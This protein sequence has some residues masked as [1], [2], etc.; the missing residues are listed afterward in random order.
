MAPGLDRALSAAANPS[1]AGLPLGS[2][3]P[4]LPTD[5]KALSVATNPTLR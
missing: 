4:E 3:H 2:S 5:R 1:A